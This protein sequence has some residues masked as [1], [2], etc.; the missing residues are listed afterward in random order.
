MDSNHDSILCMEI[1]CKMQELESLKVSASKMR[2][3]ST[4]DTSV[5]FCS[6][7]MALRRQSIDEYYSIYHEE[8][9]FTFYI[10]HEMLRKSQ[11]LAEAAVSGDSPPQRFRGYLA[12]LKCIP[13]EMGSHCMS[14]PAMFHKVSNQTILRFIFFLQLG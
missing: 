2:P 6:M 13:S 5:T 11:Q 9:N 4:P 8:N 7:Q 14:S 12:G 10:V 1:C 3:K